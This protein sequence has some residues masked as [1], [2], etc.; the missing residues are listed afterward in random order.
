MNLRWCLK[1]SLH[2]EG[3]VYSALSQRVSRLDMDMLTQK[4][5]HGGV[6]L[7]S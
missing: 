5:H 7:L 4:F 1:K 3:S 6:P 2:Q